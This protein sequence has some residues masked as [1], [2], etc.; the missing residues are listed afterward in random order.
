[1]LNL[2]L[3]QW[4]TGLL[5]RPRLHW[6]SL[7]QHVARPGEEDSLVLAQCRSPRQNIKLQLQG[8]QHTCQQP[9]KRPRSCKVK[10]GTRTS[11]SVHMIR[12]TNI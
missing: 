1:M 3:R 2:P 10:S 4:P 8:R 9:I 7:S 12:A 11:L 6:M 5:L